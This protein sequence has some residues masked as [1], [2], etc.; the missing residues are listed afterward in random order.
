MGHEIVYCVKCATK[1][2]GV[3][4][5]RGKAFKVGGKHVCSACLP[6]LTIEEQKEA[7]LSS[8]RMRTMKAAPASAQGTS[9]RTSL[10]RF[11]APP[12]S[13]ATMILLC[14]GGILMALAGVL[15][16]AVSRGSKPVESSSPVA[17]PPPG[18]SIPPPSDVERPEDIQLRN[19]EAAVELARAKMKSAP[20]DLDAQAAAW[21]EAVRKAALTPLYKDASSALQDVLNRQ[22]A[23]KARPRVVERPIEKPI[24]NPVVKPPVEPAAKPPSPELKAFQTRWEAAMAKAS[25]RDIDGA[26][27]DLGRAAAELADEDL[28]KGARADAEDLK[29]AG[30]LLSEAQSAFSRLSRGQAITLA[31]RNE[32]GEPLQVSGT[33]L[34]AAASRVE[35][36]SGEA[37]VF[38][39]AEDVGVAS[40]AGLLGERT[41]PERR[42]LAILC[43][44]EADREGAERLVEADVL[45]PRWRAYAAGA[46][47][48]PPIPGPRELEARA[49][50][51]TAEREFA[52]M[53]T[54]AAAVPKYKSLAAD[55]ADTRVVRSEIHR[56]QKR[57]EAGKEYLILS[58]G[59]KGSGAFGLAPAPRTEVAWISR[60]NVEGAQAAE[61]FVE[62]EFAALP[63]LTYRCWALVGGCCA[64]NFTFYLQ[65]TEGLEYS[66]KARQKASID[67]GA[68][69]AA[70]VKHSLSNLKKT[71]E[72]HKIKGAKAH[73]KTASRWE[74]IPIPLPKYSAPGAKK[75]RLISDQQGFGVGA[76]VVSAT[77]SGPVAE[78]ELKE[79]VARARASLAAAQEGLVGWWRLDETSGSLASDAVEGGH[80]GKLMGNPKWGPGKVGGALRFDQGDEVKIQGAFAFR[81]LSVS[82]WVKHDSISSAIQRYVTLSR[83][84]AVLRCEG[85]KAHFYIRTN[86]EL[87][88]LYVPGVME[89]GKWMMI[90]GTWDGLTQRL[91]K[92]GVLIGSLTPGGTLASEVSGLSIGSNGEAMR[93]QIDEVRLYNRALSEAEIKKLQVEGAQGVI[94]EMTSA[95]PLPVGKPWRPLFDGTS[96][97]VLRGGEGSWKAETGALVYIPGTDDAA[98][99][100]EDFGDGE[101]RIRFE[102]KDASI[103]WF[104]LRQGAASGYSV[105]WENE[106]KSLEGKPHE[107]IFTAKGDQVTA[108]LDGKPIPV[109]C[110]GPSK[111]GPLQ[112]NA[113]GKLCR[114]LSIDV[115]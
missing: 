23:M 102:V 40:L 78:P 60:E 97:S 15:I 12:S 7:S 5:E 28:R 37:A 25:A 112:F 63:E 2:P 59:L 65:T 3:D 56:V 98:Q 101:M 92:D 108:T 74:W 111:S 1:I 4:F 99:T 79:E 31:C 24:E 110:N 16:F 52:K 64:E 36:R 10:P 30:A 9:V 66:P 68:G 107:L 32:K 45:P 71:H 49:R 70:L 89:A 44:L 42:A 13:G 109:S 85:D 80:D 6:T 38:V 75:I 69:L 84:T 88:H 114:I 87:R 67:P 41:E 81:T 96:L 26:I 11:D 83:E 54:L 47:A 22:A 50:F 14:G 53:E 33:V 86:G 29:Q 48:K 17:R 8:T 91:Y 20:D 51:Y 39:E 104:N 55:Y 95:P 73:P 100:R 35:I 18:V 77:R 93:G 58:N 76:V 103:V 105:G 113:K 19:A 106:I 57:A 46:A 90:T 82:A 21:E 27:S 62:L 94:A 43:L 115:R 72:E 34:R 61:N